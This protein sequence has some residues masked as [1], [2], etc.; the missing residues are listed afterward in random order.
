M[1]FTSPIILCLSF[2]ALK[3]LIF[4]TYWLSFGW[5]ECFVKPKYKI[6]SDINLLVRNAFLVSMISCFSWGWRARY[7]TPFLLVLREH[8][9][10]K[11][12]SKIGT[13]D[14]LLENFWFGIFTLMLLTCSKEGF[15]RFII[16]Y[17]T[18]I[19]HLP[20]KWSQLNDISSEFCCFKLFLS[21]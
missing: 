6:L 9:L 12:L 4:L 10:V 8:L 3:R 13:I 2:L 16:A 15:P 14:H 21:S 1:W 11:S 7:L 17:L 5:T 18:Y 19:T 20:L